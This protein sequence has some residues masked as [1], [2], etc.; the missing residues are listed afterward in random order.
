MGAKIVRPTVRLN[1]QCCLVLLTKRSPIL[2]KG[3]VSELVLVTAVYQTRVPGM[4]CHR[5]MVQL[6]GRHVVDVGA[7][8]L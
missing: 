6:G 7:F 4:Y 1:K 5:Q 8:V 3:A 2:V